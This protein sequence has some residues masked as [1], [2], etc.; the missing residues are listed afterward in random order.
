M[1]PDTMPNGHGHTNSKPNGISKNTHGSTISHAA[2]QGRPKDPIAIIGIS[3]KFGGSATDSSKLW[4]LVVTGKSAWS[5]IPKDRFDVKSSYHADKD[6][7]GRVCCIQR[8]LSFYV[9]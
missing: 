9:A 2:R 6:R 7:P 4:E 1:A 3:A 8:F 5:P